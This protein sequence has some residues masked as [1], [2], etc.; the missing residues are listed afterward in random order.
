MRARL[1]TRLRTAPLVV[2]LCCFS[3]VWV[4]DVWYSV[5]QQVD[6]ARTRARHDAIT[7]A[8]N[9]ARLVEEHTVRTI[10]AADQALQFIKHEFLE[11]GN[12][13]DLGQLLADG[14][15]PGDIANL[16]SIIGPGGDVVLAS[17]PWK[18]VNVADRDHVRVHLESN[19]V[20]LVISK[21]V[22]GR[23]T[24]R[25]SLQLTRRIDLRD[26]RFAG[27]AS[28]SI[29]P[30]YFSRL[31]QSA[32][33]SPNSIVTLVGADGVV[34]ARRATDAS[35][36]GQDLSGS[37]Q[38]R[39]I[40]SQRSG[41]VTGRSHIDGRMRTSAF[42]RLKD[43]PLLVVVGIDLADIEHSLVPLRS[44]QVG[45]AVVSTVGIVL[46][47]AVLLLLTRRLLLSRTQAVNANAAKSQFLSNMSHELRTPLNGILGYAELL[48]MEAGE[49]EHREYAGVIHDSGL[50]L[51]SLVDQLLQLNRMEAQHEGPT[52]AVEDIRKLICEVIAAHQD[53]ARSKA[54]D[55]RAWVAEHVPER[56]ECD[57]AKLVQVLHHLL[58]NAIRFTEAGSVELALTPRE[59]TLVFLVADTGPGIPAALQ[60][61]VFDKFYQ[62]DSSDSRRSA[63]AGLGLS[64]VRELVAAMG[65]EVGITSSP[66]TGA[67]FYFTLP[68]PRDDDGRAV[69]QV[70]T[71]EM[72]CAHPPS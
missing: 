33:L 35:T 69:K 52:L 29:D 66:G 21:P 62:I 48:K 37:E 36:I 12:E 55:L 46:F 43:Y 27:V 45:Q 32:Q 57:R 2:A 19:G 8:S 24:G 6:A 16:Y 53:A 17:R 68:C 71:E 67:T 40:G 14:V 31:Y 13:L 1:I 39:Q 22:L 54:L 25:W 7:E 23:I 18:A 65:G 72:A 51:L 60:A 44:Q 3:A 61:K 63:G 10:G 41:L 50:H 70:P 47:T 42:R 20:G 49:A 26:G 38:F 5:G 56:L 64:L 11:K 9:F 28:V 59:D 30:F 4:A 34:R 58:D 15:I